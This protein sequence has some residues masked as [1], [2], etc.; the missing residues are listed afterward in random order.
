MAQ[1]YATLELTQLFV[2]QHIF[3][4]LHQEPR[5]QL[6]ARHLWVFA[7]WHFHFHGDNSCIPS[8]Q[9]LSKDISISMVLQK[10]QPK[11]CLI[12]NSWNPF[13]FILNSLSFK[14]NLPV[15]KSTSKSLLYLLSKIHDFGF[16]IYFYLR[17]PRM[18]FLFMH[19]AFW[20][21]AD[22]PS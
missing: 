22:S 20:E 4:A 11:S 1:L 8:P 21:Q 12:W 18:I 5:I 15:P 14:I 2:K 9:G 19:C 6:H 3:Q 7:L 10:N 17:V 13:Q 16:Q